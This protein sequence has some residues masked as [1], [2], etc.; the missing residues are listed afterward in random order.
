MITKLSSA[1]LHSCTPTLL[2]SLFFIF[3]LSLSSVAA[4][5]P[6]WTKKAAKSVVTVKTFAADG[7]LIGSA[8]G[9]FVGE[10][11][12]TVSA[13]A[14]FR[15]AARAVVV[16]GA[17][18]E[19]DVACIMGANDTYDVTKF[20]VSVKKSQP[21]VVAPASQAV[22]TKL[23]Q[24]PY[25]EE[26]RVGQCVV[27]KVETFGDGYSYY[28]LAMPTA[29]VMVGTPLLN[30]DGQVVGLM[31]ASVNNSDTTGYAVS[32]RFADSLTV[33]GLSLND[34]SMRAIG[35]K[36]ALPSTLAQT[37][38][39]LYVAPSSLDSVA[40]AQ[41]VDDVI[42]QY[43]EAVDGYQA[44][45][46]LAVTA[47]DFAAAQRDMEQALKAVEKKDEAHY[48]YS[49]LILQKAVYKADQPYEPWTL[50][51]AYAEAAEAYRLNPQP[52]YLHQQAQTLFAQ[53]RYAEACDAYLQLTTTSMRSAETFYEAGRCKLMQNDTVA[54]L[55]LL[56]S[57]VAQFAQP[58]L[59]EAAPYLMVRARARASVGKYREAV[60]DMNDYEALMRSQLTDNFYYLR[61]QAEIG[62]RLFQQA[63]NDIDKAIEMAPANPFYLS[64]KASLQI[65]VGLHADA[66]Q[67][68]R[69]L[70]EQEPKQSDGYLFLGLAQC[71]A[72][73]KAEGTKNLQKA[74]EMGDPQA[75][76]LLEKYGK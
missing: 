23:W 75:A 4:Q 27:R 30:D 18:K 15:G 62:G 38:L 66:Q 28:T 8:T 69:Q 25:R 72:G 65:R 17:G 76:S 24:L 20:R 35:I 33:S 32:A 10:R 22:G 57:A 73:D 58:Y 70:I 46:Q 47:G 2:I 68:A 5:V 71:L 41:L 42:S 44:R 39:M 31:Q 7:T 26:K 54:Y 48:A 53:K 50:E 34:P 67:T 63:L 52:S 45:A 13:Y 74:Q 51:L 6:S 19:Y 3:H 12:E 64:E 59:K 55:A 29:G 14:P 16:D 40:Y 43:P 36:K 11:G 9:F 49:R 61:H 21:L 1:L 60:V 37:Q 56:D